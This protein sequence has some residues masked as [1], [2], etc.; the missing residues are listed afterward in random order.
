M[1]HKTPVEETPLRKIENCNVNNIP[2]SVSKKPSWKNASMM[3]AKLFAWQYALDRA[4]SEM[5]L[6]VSVDW[7]KDFGINSKDLHQANSKMI[8]SFD[9]MYENQARKTPAGEAL[10]NRLYY[11]YRERVDG[12][13]I[14]RISKEHP[15]R[16]SRLL[17]HAVTA[18][19][20]WRAAKPMS[21]EHIYS[22]FEEK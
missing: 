13:L 1:Q 7:N 19:N 15:L 11:M 8:L 2:G 20:C 5:A 12:E 17:P 16:S 21:K 10:L 4:G 3:L 9:E 6:V 22:L 14:K 18:S